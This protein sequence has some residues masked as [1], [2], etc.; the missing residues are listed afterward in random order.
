MSG[1]P[2]AI[3]LIIGL[4]LAVI[5]WPTGDGEKNAKGNERDPAKEGDERI[6]QGVNNLTYEEQLEGKLEA[7]LSKVKGVGEV[8]V[9]ITLISSSELVLQ[10]DEQNMTD[11]VSETDS[12]GGTT[13]SIQSENTRETVL[14]GSAEGP[15]VIKEINPQVSGV[16]IL[17]QGAGSAAVKNEICEAVEALFNLPIHKIKVLEAE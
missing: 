13:N 16:L 14:T 4:L 3:L 7:I 2:W 15:F 8:K 5:A 10:V 11:K 1:K 6:A 9:M 17:A 12:D